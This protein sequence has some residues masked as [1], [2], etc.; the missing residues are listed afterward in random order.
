VAAF[1]LQKVIEYE[2]SHEQDA[3]KVNVRNHFTR[4]HNRAYNET[5]LQIKEYESDVATLKKEVA[6]LSRELKAG[7]RQSASVQTDS[8]ALTSQPLPSKEKERYLSGR[9]LWRER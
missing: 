6:S 7:R 1:L 3:S 2:Y 5:T 8:E 4:E 9:G